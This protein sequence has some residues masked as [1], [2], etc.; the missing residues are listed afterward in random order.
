[1]LW[2][3]EM[4]LQKLPEHVVTAGAVPQMVMGVTDRQAG[5]ERIFFGLRQPCVMI[6]RHI[7]SAAMRPVQVDPVMGPFYPL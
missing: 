3:P 4:S 2:P 7:V 6:G 5:V 1:M